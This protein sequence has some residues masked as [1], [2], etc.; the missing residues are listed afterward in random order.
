MHTHIYSTHTT[1]MQHPC[2]TH[3]LTPGIHACTIHTHHR[4]IHTHSHHTHP[5]TLYAQHTYIINAPPT[6]SYDTYT[7]VPIHTPQTHT[8]SIYIGTYTC[9][10]IHTPHTRTCTCTHIIYTL[11]IPHTDSH[12]MYTHTQHSP[13]TKQHIHSNYTYTHHTH[14]FH[15]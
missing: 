13:H 15:E 5:L 7:Y 8:H 14:I 10:P 1:P 2:N 9:S 4:H 6:H 11:P 3:R 12:H